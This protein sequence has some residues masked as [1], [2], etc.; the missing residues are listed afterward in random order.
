MISEK[1]VISIDIKAL[2]AIIVAVVTAAAVWVSLTQ[3][4]EK[5]QKDVIRIEEDCED[6]TEWII[7]YEPTIAK[8]T[9][10]ELNRLKIEGTLLKHR[11]TQ[12]EYKLQ[13]QK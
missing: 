5:L 8:E 4:M 1:S 7:N 12:L 2:I 13:K 10:Q 6:N 3:E 11:T 9:V